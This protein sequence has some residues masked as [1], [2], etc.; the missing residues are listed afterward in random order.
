METSIAGNARPTI[1]FSG[2]MDDD[3]CIELVDRIRALRDDLFFSEVQLRIA[4]PGGQLSALKYL[5]ES[6][7]EL[8]ADGLTL[9]TH[10]IT[11][12]GS[13]A[14]VMLSLGDVRTAHRKSLLLYH[15]GRVPGVD[16]TI[17]A[18]SAESL[19]TELHTADDEIV[20]LLVDR[21]ALSP[22]P[23]AD[24]PPD[25]FARWDWPVI[26]W[27]SPGNA[28]KT[29]TTLRRFRKRVA[30][31]FESEN[32]SA[33][34]RLYSDFCALDSPV[35]PYLA[36]ELGLIDGV[37]DSSPDTRER[38]E[39]PNDGGLA[40]PEW[41]ALYTGGLVPRAAFT[42]H[43]LI[44]GESGS[45]KTASGVLPV[46]SAVAREGSPVSCA[47]VI[48][49]K[50]DLLPIA[51]D[52]AAPDCSIHLLRA[53]VDSVNMMTGSRSVAE[54]VSHGRWMTAAQKI[55]ARTA[56]FS[57]S[58]ARILA[59]RPASS[60]RNAFW[61]IEGSRLAQCVLALTLLVSRNGLLKELQSNSESLGRETR[62]RLAAFGAFAGLLGDHTE[63]PP[64]NVLATAHRAL[65]DLFVTPQSSS[66]P[67]WDVIDALRKTG[68]V[69]DDT[70]AIHSE[71]SYWNEV[72]GAVNQFS[73]ILGEARAC[74]S[75]FADPAPARSLF[76]GVEPSES[77]VDFTPAVGADTVSAGRSLY[78]YQPDLGDEHALIAKALKGCFFEAILA[79]AARRARGG[80]MPLVCYLADEFH[81]FITSDSAHGEQSFLDTCRSFGAGCV[82]ATQ[83][84][85]SVRHALALAGEPAPDTAIRILMTN[86]ATKILFRS[87]EDGVRH[88][89]DGICPGYGP[90]R[91][92][93]L[94]PPATLRPGEC[95]ASLPDG[96]FERRQ[97]KQFEPSTKMI[98][99]AA[100]R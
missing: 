89:V 95:Y 70:V 92:T 74:F 81:R 94:R 24:T 84:D 78:V 60:A 71:V 97:L 83:S 35:S 6:V 100:T 31:A 50:W 91:V 73:G 98:E 32:P 38:I 87:T 69:D 39:D 99:R 1:H 88:L 17:T 22:A 64:M 57:D 33:L 61:E 52:L 85:A 5:A 14:A 13:A 53:G 28:R 75:A 79:C 59:G 16:G 93:V 21:A 20:S 80:T 40:V 12:V 45:G 68:T 49:P 66:F 3:N 37:G 2:P 7:R 55:L 90:H 96:R 8:Q 86:T 27:L 48:D 77:T 4:S 54:D 44:L 30:A 25:R 18:R 76:F 42:R 29:S 26:G 51:R 15:T 82:L 63:T 43:T 10:A 46:L 58:P 65:N 34:R 56:T 23:E 19:A 36:R 47:L 9:A 41:E 62:N 11:N 67:A 72:R